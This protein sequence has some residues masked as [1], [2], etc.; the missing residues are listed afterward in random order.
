MMIK[1][2]PL[3]ISQDHLQ[4]IGKALE[5]MPFRVSAPIIAEINRQIKEFQESNKDTE[6]SE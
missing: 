6:G 1:T 2:F 4:V 3:S 5:E